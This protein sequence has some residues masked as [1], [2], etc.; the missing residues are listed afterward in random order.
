MK[1]C[2]SCKELKETTEFHK[3][4][5]RKDGLAWQCKPCKKESARQSY[6]RNR[7]IIQERIRAYYQKNKEQIKAY[8]KQY[9]KDNIEK[10]RISH[11]KKEGRRRFLKQATQLHGNQ[12][13]NDLVFQEAYEIASLRSE[14]TGVKHHVDHIIP[15]QGKEVCGFHVWNNIQVLPYYENCSKSNKFLEE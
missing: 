14:S 3:S 5:D 9:A 10:A 13:L 12:E 8:S 11:A 4:S 7:D 15:L 6:L 2:G 1:V